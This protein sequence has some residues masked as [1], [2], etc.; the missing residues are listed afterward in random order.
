MNINA[1]GN[2]HQIYLSNSTERFVVSDS[3]DYYWWNNF[4]RSY[5]PIDT[6]RFGP[7]SP[8]G[9]II[10]VDIDNAGNLV[11][12]TLIDDAPGF[13][14]ESIL[15]TW[16]ASSQSFRE[17]ENFFMEPWLSSPGNYPFTY[18]S[19]TEFLL[20][21]NGDLY[22][23]TS[24]LGG[25]DG[26]NINGIKLGSNFATT[27][28][29]LDGSAWALDDKGQAWIIDGTQLSLFNGSN[30]PPLKQLSV[31][32]SSRIY[33]LGT[34]G[35]IYQWSIGSNSFIDLSNLLNSVPP[36]LEQIQVDEQ[37]ILYGISTQNQSYQLFDTTSVVDIS[38]P[39]SQ[40][41]GLTTITTDSGV[42]HAIWN[43]NGQIYYGYSNAN[44]PGQ[45]IGVAPLGSGIGATPQG[46]STDLN[47]INNGG[48]IQAYWLS[49]D[50]NDT[51]VY[52]SS[53]SSSPYGG[54]QWSN[55]QNLTNDNLADSNLEVTAL[56]NN[57]VLITTQKQGITSHQI[58]DTSQLTSIPVNNTSLPFRPQGQ[59]FVY[60]LDTAPDNSGLLEGVQGLPLPKDF[61]IS[62]TKKNKDN[63]VNSTTTSISATISGSVDQT[64][65]S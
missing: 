2:L 11:F 47:L 55:P 10:G 15:T 4:N 38:N 1:I 5:Q 21:F 6:S 43:E 14:P 12:L 9:S 48:N 23:L 40:T 64:H 16:N 19:S 31:V 37:G 8:S 56:E 61:S 20:I 30:N 24:P 32:D 39:N 41:T 27:I 28:A 33:G 49:S 63:D 53:L 46:S 57:Q 25:W 34:D 13:P 50:G 17:S 58:V 65:I 26:N 54:Y 22:Q 59:G 60:D 18:I 51:E 44:N 29:R 42:T 3:G 62:V 52:S 7:N 45:Y 35:K 36:I